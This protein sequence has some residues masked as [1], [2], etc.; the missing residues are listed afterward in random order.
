MN[1]RQILADAIGTV[2]A[3][4]SWLEN[5]MGRSD[6]YVELAL[7]RSLEVMG[8]ASLLLHEAEYHRK[9]PHGRPG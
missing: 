9:D 2:R 3:C 6:G 8:K 7:R 4:E 5:L 1:D